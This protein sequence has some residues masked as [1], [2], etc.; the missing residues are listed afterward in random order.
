MSSS[1][2]PHFFDSTWHWSK[3][4]CRQEAAVWGRE[5]IGSPSSPDI[6]YWAELL[7][8]VMELGVPVN[9]IH[10]SLSNHAFDRN[11]APHR[12]CLA[13][14]PKTVGFETKFY[15]TYLPSW[16]LGFRSG[17]RTNYGFLV[18]VE[19]EGTHLRFLSRTRPWNSFCLL[20]KEQNRTEGQQLFVWPL[21]FSVVFFS[22]CLKCYFFSSWKFTDVKKW[23][24][25]ILR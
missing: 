6:Y 7:A 23:L 19:T 17:N 10:F 3:L 24:K 25:V 14:V 18:P 11:I 15:M 5:E 21:V 8:S 4:W 1:L 13:L 12:D 16:C 20:V 2:F 22:V 9:R